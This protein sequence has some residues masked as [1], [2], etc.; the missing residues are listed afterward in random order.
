MRIAALADVHGNLPA[1]RAA[2]RD[3]EAAEPDLVV[4]CGD[5]TWGSLPRET[6]DFVRGRELP[7]RFVRGNA[8]RALLEQ[9]DDR[10][11]ARW[12]YGQHTAD[13]LDWLR[14]FEPT[15]SVG[16]IRFCHGS[17][18]HDEDI[19]TPITP[20]A[21]LGPLLEGVSE[22]TVVSA[23]IHV[24]FDRT[25]DGVRSIN[26]GSIGLPYEGRSGG[27]YWAL[28]DGDDVALRRTEYDVEETCALFAA[29]DDPMREA[30]VQELRSPTT[31][32]EMVPRAEQLERSG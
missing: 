13:D 3:I 6:I 8:E 11:R 27:A 15:V 10:E 22:R 21:R 26:P 2:W 28:I 18:Q 20:P 30:I 5:L 32:E 9:T 31:R 29:T 12:M 17:P 23:H 4:S 16:G 7:L 14:S 24:Q 25:I 19:I 1:L